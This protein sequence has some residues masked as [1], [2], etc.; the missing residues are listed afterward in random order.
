MKINTNPK[1]FDATIKLIYLNN[2]NFK[3]DLEKAIDLATD[4]LIELAKRD[5]PVDTG[6]LQMNIRKEPIKEKNTYGWTVIS[7]EGTYPKKYARYVH[8][9]TFKMRARPY[10]E[11]RN[12]LIVFSKLRVK[13]FQIY[14]KHFSNRW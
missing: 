11:G 6:N 5:V 14:K 8:D 13:I 7:D 1:D 2:E 10:L 4:N 12:A 9:G 3:K